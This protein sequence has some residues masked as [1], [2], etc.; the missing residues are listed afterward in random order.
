LAACPR[1]G[2]DPI[3]DGSCIEC[4]WSPPA[5]VPVPALDLVKDRDQLF[6]A[7]HQAAPPVE[8]NRR[9]APKFFPGRLRLDDV[10]IDGVQLAA[11][12]VLVD[13]VARATIWLANAS[14]GFRVAFDGC[15]GI[16]MGFY[17]GLMLLKDVGSVGWLRDG[18]VW[19]QGYSI[20]A[21]LVA[22]MIFNLHPGYVATVLVIPACILA[23]LVAS[24]PKRRLAGFLIGL[25]AEGAYFVLVLARIWLG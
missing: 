16:A 21:T 23:T 13:A 12:L 14:S 20:A 6:A 25:A 22:G 18:I 3:G 1:C 11:V 4:G 9:R 5:P 10:Q 24:S 15:N 8:Y 2:R 7:A 17:V 19:L